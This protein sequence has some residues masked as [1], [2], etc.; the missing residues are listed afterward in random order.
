MTCGICAVQE[1]NNSPCATNT[2]VTAMRDD[3]LLAGW[4]RCAITSAGLDTPNLHPGGLE[5]R[6]PLARG[7][8]VGHQDVER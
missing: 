1:A 4:A 5:L 6:Q 3:R 7:G 8:R 2:A